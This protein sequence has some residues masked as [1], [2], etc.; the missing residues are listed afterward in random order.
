MSAPKMKLQRG[1]QVRIIAGSHK[2]KTGKIVA[3]LPRQNA[4]KV[5]GLNVVKRH[6]KPSMLNPQGGS[7]EIHKPIDASKVALLTGDK[8][9]LTSKVGFSTKKDGTKTRT[10]R[11]LNNK[12]IK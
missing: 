9:T 11:K 5:E 8:K 10:L 7:S 2:G 1:D 4:V 6:L 12:E 3:V